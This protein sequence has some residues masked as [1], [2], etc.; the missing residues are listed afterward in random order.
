MR[1]RQHNFQ[2]LDPRK[3]LQS[4]RSRWPLDTSG[5]SYNVVRWRI[6][7]RTVFL[8]LVLVTLAFVSADADQRQSD[9]TCKIGSSLQSRQFTFKA[10]QRSREFRHP[11]PIKLDIRTN[12]LL[13]SAAQTRENKSCYRMRTF[14]VRRLDNTDSTEPAGYSTCLAASQVQLKNA[15]RGGK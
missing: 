5:R 3:S 10:A 8:A 6:D 13:P 2:F 9:P 7:M 4:A 1:S 15:D 12:G 11:D 14:Q